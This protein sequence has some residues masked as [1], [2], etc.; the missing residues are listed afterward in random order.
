MCS[1]HVLDNSHSFGQLEDV[2]YIILIR[3]TRRHVNTIERFYV[4]QETKNEN[5]L[6][7][8]F[9]Q[10]KKIVLRLSESTTSRLIIIIKKKTHKKTYVY[11]EQSVSLIKTYNAESES[12]NECSVRRSK[13]LYCTS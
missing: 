11:L 12:E 6:S 8:I 10:Y 13:A 4:Y 9:R 5:K 1:Q 3:K 2:M 7:K